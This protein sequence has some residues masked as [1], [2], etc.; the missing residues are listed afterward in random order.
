MCINHCLYL[1]ATESTE[2]KS[3]VISVAI[4]F[5]SDL[6]WILSNRVKH[7]TVVLNY[8]NNL[9][10]WLFKLY[11]SIKVILILDFVQKSPND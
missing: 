3:S 8:K 9:K 1:S 10:S 7:R 11:N 4:F 2:K 5:P 6:K